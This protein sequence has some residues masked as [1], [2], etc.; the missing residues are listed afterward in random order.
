MWRT[1]RWRA[2][3]ETRP[4]T[5][6]IWPLA[7]FGRQRFPYGPG[8]LVQTVVA[9]IQR[10]TGSFGFWKWV[11]SAETAAWRLKWISIP[12]M[13]VSLWFG[14]K[15]YRSIRL[16]PQRFCGLK[17]ARSGLLASSM[18]ALLI[19]LLIGVTVPARLRHRQMAKEAG[20]QAKRYTFERAMLE[21]QLKY[22]LIL[23]TTKIYSRAFRIPMGLSPRSTRV[24][25]DPRSADVA[26]VTNE[27]SRSLRGAVIRNAALSPRHRR[28]PPGGLSFTRYVMR[29]A[30]EDK[31]MGTEDDWIASDG[32]IK[33][34]SDVAKGGVGR[35]MSAGSP[36][37]IA[38]QCRF[39]IVSAREQKT[40]PHESARLSKTGRMTD[41]EIIDAVSENDGRI[42]QVTY[43]YMLAGV[44]YESSQALSLPQ[45]QRSSD[46]A[47]GR[48]IVVR[49]DPRSPAN[50]IVV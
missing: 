27:K 23:P 16:Q 45:Q 3:P 33:K 13:F 39:S 47:P 21:Y 1:R 7:D 19:A 18:V 4:R 49:Y 43:T 5:S 8:L 36:A 42:T 37:T 35:S 29:F 20:I 48:Q 24:V 28:S 31:I 6:F 44:Q 46:Y 25:I 22:K 9:F 30:G 12:V 38:T 34:Y 17:Y 40:K 41:G 2:A 11:A 14:R 10:G 32:M 15:I 50:S 26:A